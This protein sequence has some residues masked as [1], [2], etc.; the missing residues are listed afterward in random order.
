[1]FHYTTCVMFCPWTENFNIFPLADDLAHP[2]ERALPRALRPGGSA[3]FHFGRP[4]F[5]C[6]LQNVISTFLLQPKSLCLLAGNAGR[7]R[8]WILSSQERPFLPLACPLVRLS[9]SPAENCVS[10]LI[11]LGTRTAP[12]ARL[13]PLQS[14]HASRILESCYRG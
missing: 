10:A 12:I 6:S 7:C 14:L 11:S 3:T 8:S 5:P 1:M 9:S 13:F 2:T 4:N